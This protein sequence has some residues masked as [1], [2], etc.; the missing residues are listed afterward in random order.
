MGY[1]ILAYG[2]L[3]ALLILPIIFVTRWANSYVTR[4]LE[5][6]LRSIQVII[7]EEGIPEPWQAPFR[8]QAANLRL[9]N[10]SPAQLAK[11]EEKTKTGCLRRIDELIKYCETFRITDGS[12]SQKALLEELRQH[13][14]RWAEMSWQGQ[15]DPKPATADPAT[16]PP[17]ETGL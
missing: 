8:K 6:R 5:D 12:D 4:D 7:N 13:R 1:M 10:G 16:L 3:F 15:L 11:I 9:K 14:A 2:A 17:V